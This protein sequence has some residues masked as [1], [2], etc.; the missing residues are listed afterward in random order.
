VHSFEIRIIKA[1]EKSIVKTEPGFLFKNGRMRKITVTY[2]DVGIEQLRESALIEVYRRE[3]NGK[4]HRFSVEGRTNRWIPKERLDQYLSGEKTIFFD[5][6]DVEG[7]M[8]YGFDKK[9]GTVSKDRTITYNKQTYYVAS[10]AEKFSRRHSTKVYVSHVNGKLLVFEYRKDGIL[11]GDALCQEPSKTPEFKTNQA[12][13]R[14][15]INEVEQIGAFLETK[16]MVVNT[17]NLIAKH[18]QGLTLA[19][20]KE[21]YQKN[22]ARYDTYS[23]RLKHAPD[24]LAAALFNA[25]LIDYD[26]EKRQDHVAPY[27]AKETMK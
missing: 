24:K 9:K 2:L 19:M 18:R 10:G 23:V 20:A 21:I 25:F 16:G 1:F 7:F 5:P 12:L 11:L 26:R 3:H 13:K 17:V 15:Q 8:Q 14:I 27:A 4:R 22:Q 6:E